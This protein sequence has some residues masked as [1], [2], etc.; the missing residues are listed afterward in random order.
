MRAGIGGRPTHHEGD[1]VV[2]RRL[3][4]LTRSTRDLPELAALIDG[5]AKISTPS[6]A[7]GLAAMLASRRWLRCVAVLTAITAPT[8]G[9]A[10]PFVPTDDAE[11]LE[12]LP[13]PRD[14]D[15]R[16]LRRLRAELNEDPS[17]L[18]L[19]L[20]LARRYIG[21]S[22]AESDPRYQGYAQAALS[23]WWDL[24]DP[25][26]DVLVLRATL[27]QGR[28]D[29]DG[30]LADLSAVLA[31]EPRNAQA[32]LTRAVILQVQGR[33]TEAVASCARLSRLASPLVAAACAA[34]AAGRNGHAA[35]SYELLR[36]A[37]D[38]APDADAGV[39]LWALTILAEIAERR[40]DHRAAEEHFRQALALGLRDG[41]LLGAYADFLLDRGRAAE[42]RDLL[43]DEV[44]ADGLLLRL[45]L[46]EQRL[47]DPDLPE[48][49]AMLRARFDASRMRGDALHRREEARF[50]LRLLDQPERA[51]RL[52]E[53]NWRVQREPWDAR[54]VLEAALA[55]GAPSA[56]APVVDWLRE[57]RLEDA[58]IG[59]LIRR[60]E[61][62]GL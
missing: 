25:P 55:A 46:A 6:P 36:E 18:G 40:G 2:V 41:Y 58:R 20:R 45:A 32:W 12:R 16:E 10:E 3:D 14:A 27:R 4:R 9:T 54:L 50:A 24:R 43:A 30:A 62:A 5:H 33:Y 23:P 28:H 1:A 8:P 26:A 11:V 61:A 29:F 35:E 60:L 39:R 37:L 57:A 49:V 13:A 44:R 42:V 31:A 56:A 51:L 47:D 38:D 7:A 21:V 48:H 22:R 34:D 52:A 59:S 53:E 15:A 17:D 19:A